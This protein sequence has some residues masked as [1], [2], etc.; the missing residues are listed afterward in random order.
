MSLIC[1]VIQPFDGASYDARYDEIVEPAVKSAGFTP[2]RVDRDQYVSSLVQQIERGIREADAILADISEDN[3]N[4]WFEVG[5]SVAYSK[6][7][8]LICSKKRKKLPFDVAH[9]KVVFY[10][11]GDFVSLGNLHADIKKKLTTFLEPANKKRSI[12]GIIKSR[13]KEISDAAIVALIFLWSKEKSEA[14]KYELIR[15]IVQLGLTIEFAAAEILNLIKIGYIKKLSFTSGESE[16]EIFSIT[17]DGE[18]YILE[19]KARL[20]QSINDD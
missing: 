6:N 10:E 7:I 2:Y 8:C 17:S 1:F 16:D 18:L 9:R 13:K 4:V 20:V 5:M 12:S 11:E 3:P 19:S 15:S 14:K